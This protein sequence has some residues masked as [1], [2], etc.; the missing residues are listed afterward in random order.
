[1]KEY[2]SLLSFQVS[3]FGKS[4]GRYFVA[5]D[6]WPHFIQSQST[7]LSGLGAMLDSYRKLQQKPKQFPSLQMP[8]S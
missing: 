3:S 4:E 2:L 7:G 5:D 6:E 1:M 8:F